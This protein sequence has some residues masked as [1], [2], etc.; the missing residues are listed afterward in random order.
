MHVGVAGPKWNLL[1]IMK[2]FQLDIPSPLLEESVIYDYKP[3]CLHPRKILGW[4][5]VGVRFL[6]KTS[7]NVR[8]T[9]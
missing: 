4:I 7:K 6:R 3:V 2:N 8:G 1:K 9:S 5:K